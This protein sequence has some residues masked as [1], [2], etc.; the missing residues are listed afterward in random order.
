M[1]PTINLDD[2]TF[3]D[4]KDEAIR[5]IPRYCPEWTNHNAS[6]PGITLIELFSWMTE[7]TLYRLNKVPQKSYI[8]MLEL[9]G[10]SLSPPQSARAIIQFFPIEN[11]SKNVLIKNGTKIASVDSS[12]Q[13]IIFET[14]KKLLVRDSK[15]LSCINRTRESFL[16]NVDK[17]LEFS[18]FTLF[19]T[20][21]NIEHVLYISSPVFKYLR[22]G[23]IVQIYF[24]S[25]CEVLS[26]QDEIINHLYFEYWDGR[27]WSE[28]KTYSSIRGMKKKDNTVFLKG[29]VEIESSIINDIEGY[30]IRAVLADVPNRNDVTILRSIKL[31]SIFEGEGFI[32]DI[33]IINTNGNY[34]AV[35]MN[36][37][38]RL[39]S[40]TPSINESFYIAA[41]EIFKNK[42]SKV[43]LSFLF[44]EIYVPEKNNESAL[45]SYE[46]W[47]GKDWV[48]LT[49]EKNNFL[50]GTL[51]FKQSGVVSFKIPKDIKPTNV[52]NEEHLYIR[53]RLVT[54]DFAIGGVYVQD[55]NGNYQWEFNSK[56]QSPVLNKIRI[57]Y[58]AL[59]Q[60]AENLVAYSS[61]KWNNLDELRDGN[62]KEVAIFNIDREHL[63]ALYIGFSSK[64]K[65][66][67]FPLYF[68]IENS[69]FVKIKN[70]EIFDFFDKNEESIKERTNR[71]VNIEWEYWNGST[72]GKL[73][74]SDFTDNFHES[75][76]INFNIPNDLEEAFLYEKNCFWIRA[77]KIN[78]SF[79]KQ[80][81]I[82]KIIMNCVYAVNADTYQNE[83]VGSGTG[84]PGQSFYVSHPK[85]LPGIRIAV[86]EGTIP[87]KNELDKMIKD[88]IDIPYEK[89]SDKIWVNYKEVPNFYNS[90]AFSRH[91]VI[92]YSSG[93]IIFG[94]G[95]RGV[96]PPK[97]KFN[98]KI[99]EYKVGGGEIG[100]VAAHKLQFLTQS[101]PYITGCD[102]PF[103]AEGGCDME[104][105]ES[106]KSRAAGVFK[107]LNRAVTREDFEWLSCESSSS[108]GRAY[109]LENKTLDGRIRII[110][111]P[112]LVKEIGKNIKLIPSK[113]LLRRVTN[114]LND[115]KL[116]GT[117]IVVTA[118]VY[119]N[120]KIQLDLSFKNNVFN[121]DI[122]KTKI[123]EQMEIFFNPLVGGEGKGYD[124]GKTITKGL[125]LK[126]LEKNNSILSINNV[127]LFDEESG[128]AVEKLLLK[129]D[130]LPFLDGVVIFDRRG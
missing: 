104:S 116:V 22:E 85:L 58:D 62:N 90:D 17:N 70:K 93:R 129:E 36:A 92:D 100:N 43:S 35:D 55:K 3:D 99:L 12:T 8:S 59:E 119:R 79:E 87:S 32:P 75:G 110:I 109:C 39:F 80:P 76:F 33:C 7:M 64:I 19:E 128:I 78:G 50:D 44:S 9:M 91:F 49:S 89:E 37:S 130:E 21:N 125:I 117:S 65:E 14:E 52:N 61:F 84:A 101:I 42:G 2:R 82:N 98:I 96:N 34:E 67:E 4:I 108:V 120:I 57:S 107:S 53:I 126:I 31:K 46:Y 123:K 1:I 81:V 38:F 66:G 113:E 41:D 6:D 69:D 15:I 94:D 40:D 16:E 95:V 10:L 5:L 13:P 23:H 105:I 106:L 45:F 118:P 122:E 25:V 103:P 24:D 48:K 63:P 30:F 102:N 60:N 72:W 47:N 56:V 127:E 27:S 68:S 77:V 121:V 83:I 73:D 114:Y 71:Y 111:I 18:S 97:G 54:K 11:S 28:I 51:S 74:H 124:F 20:Q 112:E 29:P 86:E 88:G 115:R 26:V